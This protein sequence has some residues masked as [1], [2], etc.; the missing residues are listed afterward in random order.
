[1]SIAVSDS[2]IWVASILLICLMS[3][4]HPVS[5]MLH[6]VSTHWAWAAVP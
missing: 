3:E 1:L 5:E 2:T 4:V 6:K